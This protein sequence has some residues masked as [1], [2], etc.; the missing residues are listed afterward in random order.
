MNGTNLTKEKKMSELFR[1]E[2]YNVTIIIW[3]TFSIKYHKSQKFLH[4]GFL[5]VYW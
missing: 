1:I 4:L 5:S 2:V 3:N